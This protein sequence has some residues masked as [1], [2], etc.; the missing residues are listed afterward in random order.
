MA[1]PEK[2][3]DLDFIPNSSMVEEAER[4]LEWRSEFGRG[5]TEVGIAR[6]R[7]IANKRT[8]SPDTVKRMKSFFARHE[9]NKQAEG[10]RQGEDGYPSNGRIAWALWGGDAGMSWS[11][12]LVEQMNKRD[13][14][15]TTQKVYSIGTPT[16]LRTGTLSDVGLSSWD[17]SELITKIFTWAYDDSSDSI[18]KSKAREA[19]LIVDSENDDTQAGYKFPIAVPNSSGT[20]IVTEAGINAANS[21]LGALI[22]NP[23]DTDIPL[24]VLQRARTRLNVY[25]EMFQETDKGISVMDT[26]NTTSTKDLA[27]AVSVA[28]YDQNGTTEKN[29]TNCNF[30]E[31][32]YCERFDFN[33]GGDAFLC[34]AWQPEQNTASMHEEEEQEN[35]AESSHQGK[36]S[37]L[38][39]IVVDWLDSAFGSG[40]QTV[41]IK[42]DID[43]LVEDSEE[44][45]TII[46]PDVVED[47]P[48][49]STMKIFKNKSGRYVFIGRYSNNFLDNDIRPEIITRKAH[50]DFIDR[51][52]RGDVPMPELWIMHNEAWKVGQVTHL[53]WDENDKGQ[54]F[55]MAFALFD[56]DKGYIAEA[57]ANS[58]KSLAMSHGYGNYPVEYDDVNRN[59]II[60][61]TDHEV[62][63][64]PPDLAANKLTTSEIIGVKMINNK[65]EIADSLGIDVEHLNTLEGQNGKALNAVGSQIPSKTIDQSQEIEEVENVT[66]SETVSPEMVEIMTNLTAAVEDL[67][68][69]L[70]GLSK[71]VDELKK[72]DDEKVADVASKISMDS[73]S[74]LISRTK[75]LTGSVVGREDVKVDGRKNY[76]NPANYADDKPQLSEDM[77]E[78]LKIKANGHW[79]S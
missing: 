53:R 79:C 14:M 1:I 39:S 2:Y 37:I 4:G 41:E 56:E 24:E 57:L 65:K 59:H 77:T 73:L 40:K 18:D 42:L 35:K 13:E 64:A 16:Y 10:F 11:N 8:L 15:K 20:L 46:T 44:E 71:T 34:E 30:N 26:P 74:A 3:S 48:T 5:G 17:R 63:I 7:D 29:C 9:V 54:G 21:R 60:K 45:K 31:D 62:T 47:T 58:S 78:Q 28:N 27:T 32:G 72:S 38:K 51:A 43:D 67:K 52:T 12:K 25:R 61:L 66:E 33:H 50:I 22:N 23:S 68:A 36:L 55:A 19:F 75:G 70:S 49:E 69:Q 6:A 76:G